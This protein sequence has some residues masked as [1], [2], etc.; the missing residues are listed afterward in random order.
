M[1]KQKSIK[2]NMVM[3]TI[4]TTSN[5]IFPL[6][7]Y[8]YVARVL[9]PEGTGKVAFV[10]SVLAYFVYI[11]ALGITNYGTRE[12][13]KVRDDKDKLSKL[14]QELLTINMISTIVAYVALIITVLS[15]PKFHE[16]ETLFVVMSINIVLQ[17]LGMEWLYRALEKYTYI[18]V[19]SL[20]FKVISVIFTFVL[21][22]SPGDYVMYGAITIFTTSASNVLNFLNARKYI[23]LR[24]KYKLELKQ[25]IKPIMVFFFSVVVTTIYG[26]FDSLMLGFMKGDS[27][28]GIYNAALKMKT[29]VL[30]VSTSVTSV[31]LPRMSIYITKKDKKQFN[32]LLVKSLQLSMVLL[33]PLTFFVI[34]NAKDVILFVCG[35][36][37]LAAT[38]T[39]II[40]MLCVF[41]LSMTNILG[42]QILI[43]KGDEKRYSM[44]VFIG[45]FINLILN[46]ILIPGLAS[47][48]AAIATLATESFNVFWM[49]RG[50]KN[51]LGYMAKKFG[52]AK[53]LFALS[54]SFLL[55]LLSSRLC[56]NYNVFVR[57]C[58]NSVTM[59]GVYYI[60]LLAFKE[61]I[62]LSGIRMITKK[63]GIK[64]V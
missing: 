25:H 8:S 44:S 24:K 18:T 39:L 19:R 37:Y 26:H 13:A 51:E 12:C 64:Q 23:S 7:T 57:L 46:A 29:I 55:Y 41:A 42:N 31:L 2:L 22:K 61:P 9:Q 15:V 4:L 50:A 10:Q 28:V 21:I 16:Y 62:I 30:S 59:F 60:I 32:Q 47:A 14:A 45:M 3:N 38:N 34:L 6:I 27:E 43:P 33:V 1:E 17:T 49:G 40:L 11:S 35:D 56:V 63:M 58:L 53:Y 36:Q 52:G 20:F 54:V 48:G 5:F